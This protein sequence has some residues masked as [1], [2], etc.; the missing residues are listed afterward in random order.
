MPVNARLRVATATLAAAGVASPRVDAELLLAYL[1]GLSRSR[2]MLLDGLN[3]VQAAAFDELVRR[4]AAGEPLQYLTKS[5]A[6]R[7]LELAVGPGVFIPRPETE[8]LV[9]IASEQLKQAAIVLDL[10]AGS[11]AIALS[12]AQEYPS[13]RVIGVER[14]A[15]ALVWLHANA[16][17]REAAGDRPI[18]VVAADISEPGL[19]AE[20]NGTVDVLLTNPP[21]VPETIRAELPIEVGHDPHDAVFA[22]RDGLALM[23]AL[24]SVAARLLRPGGLLVIEHDE[25]QVM[26]LPGLLAA[27]NQ[28][29]E[30]TD[31]LD[32]AGRSRFV[33][34]VRAPE[35]PDGA[36]P[37]FFE[38]GK[39]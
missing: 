38:G 30:I 20:L 13:C 21:Y 33:T 35:M 10:C 27:A 11:G 3:D 2:L 14:S 15:A 6:F 4:R 5:A 8:L 18:E 34:A 26:T 22:G 29:L 17:A 37:R 39:I 28:W 23:P 1:L 7:H 19:L 16:A 9:E 32:L 12:V 25:T 36:K 31:L 24:L